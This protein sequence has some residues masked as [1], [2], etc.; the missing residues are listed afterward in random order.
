MH[1]FEYGCG[2]STLF[3]TSRAASVTSVEHNAVWVN[4]VRASIPATQQNKWRLLQIEATRRSD[5]ELLD[6]AD[7][8]LYASSDESHGS[9][10]FEAYARAI[11]RYPDHH[12]DIVLIDGRARPSCVMHSHRKVKPGG[13]LILDDAQ[14]LHYKAVQQCMSGGEWV[15]R[16]F[17]GPGPYAAHFWLTAIWH[18]VAQG[19]S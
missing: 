10:N 1:V 14:R 5:S 16:G 11:D 17:Y 13:F 15:H 9:S 7:P 4:L 3:F 8:E 18:R 2:G 6:P 19:R 12:F